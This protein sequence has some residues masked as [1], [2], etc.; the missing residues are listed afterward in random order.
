MTENNK[1]ME[2]LNNT[3]NSQIDD[4]VEEAMWD[5]KLDNGVFDREI[6]K[7]ILRFG[8]YTAVY[9]LTEQGFENPSDLYHWFK[10]HP[11]GSP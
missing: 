8:Y 5:F 4:W 3:F 11:L 9:T 6:V 2:L 7:K 10:G 1:V